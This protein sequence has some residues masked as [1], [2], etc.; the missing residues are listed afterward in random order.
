[1]ADVLSRR[2]LLLSSMDVTFI[3]F[4]L[5]KNLDE[6]DDE[7]CDIW[8][9]RKQM[10]KRQLSTTRWIFVQRYQTLCTQMFATANYH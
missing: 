7:F 2:T 6:K 8:F 10:S 3:G 9:K 4:E 5:L 1:M